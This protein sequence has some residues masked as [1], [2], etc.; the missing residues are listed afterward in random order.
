SGGSDG[1]KC[2]DCTPTGDM[3]FALPSPSGA[4]LWTTTTMDKVLREAAPPT[5][6]GAEI[7]LYAA[8]NEFEPFQVVIHADADDTAT[9]KLGSFTGPGTIAAGEIRRVGYVNIPSPSDASSIMSGQ[10]PDP[11]TLTSFGAMESVPGGQNQPF[12]ITVSVPKD[13]AA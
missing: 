2:T 13:A 7:Q 5:T 9:L 6:K 12:W 10:I 1:K 3:T 4:V 11:L 8:K